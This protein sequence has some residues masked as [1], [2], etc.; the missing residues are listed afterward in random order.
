MFS[1]SVSI[2]RNAARPNF[3]GYYIL[4][5]HFCASVYTRFGGSLVRAIAQPILQRAFRA[6][7]RHS[8]SHACPPIVGLHPFQ[9]DSKSSYPAGRKR[10]RRRIDFKSS[11]F[12]R[13]ANPAYR[14]QTTKGVA[15][16]RTIRLQTRR[17]VIK[18]GSTSCIS[19]AF[20]PVSKSRSDHSTQLRKTSAASIIPYPLISNTW[21]S[22]SSLVAPSR[23]R[24][25]P[26]F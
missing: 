15:V 20:M 24:Y 18:S 1:L 19:R 14:P 11:S 8:F 7:I 21:E 17:V 13:G 3:F 10:L 22:G 26:P 23:R 9:A 5:A 25:F 16:G 4:S 2:G 6:A 12:G